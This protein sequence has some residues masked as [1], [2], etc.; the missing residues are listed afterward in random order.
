LEALGW[1]VDSRVC[2][3]GEALVA[4]AQSL[5]PDD[6]DIRIQADSFRGLSALRSEDYPAA[7][8]QFDRCL[9]AMR[10]APGSAVPDYGP[11][12]RIAALV[13]AGRD[14]EARVAAAEARELSSFSRLFVCRAWLEVGEAL[15]DRSP[16]GLEHALAGFGLASAMR[17]LALS[18]GA[19]VL[20]GE[21]AGA[22]LGEA[23]RIFELAGAETDRAR[24]RRQL[25][26]LG[27]AVPRARRVDRYLPAGLRGK[28]VTPREREVLEL[29]A[30]GRTNAEIANRLFLSVRTVESHVSSL[31]AK[32]E[33]DSR[34][35]LIVAGLS[36]GSPVDRGSG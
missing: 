25:R 8:E 4:E 26:R 14:G 10:A 1:A 36:L 5:A 12:V 23:L 20:G 32:L 16:E 34:A 30:Q 11:F 24:V 18:L 7:I 21:R 27:V 22:W 29:V 17:A 35:G 28:G 15:L 19:E 33:L 6:F 13:A 3:E 31:L 9:A 2:G